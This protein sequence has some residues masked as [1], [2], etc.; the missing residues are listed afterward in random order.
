MT[1]NARIKFLKTV[2]INDIIT[3]TCLQKSINQSNFEVVIRNQK[4]DEIAHFESEVH[5]SSEL[6]G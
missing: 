3:A 5:F 2:K 1:K 4:N 6:W